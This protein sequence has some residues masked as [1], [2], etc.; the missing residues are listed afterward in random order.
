VAEI[1][2]YDGHEEF[3]ALFIRVEG[4]RGVVLIFAEEN[5]EASDLA[6][7]IGEVLDR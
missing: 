3:Y 5:P 7:E 6:R 2:Q 1:T 4:K